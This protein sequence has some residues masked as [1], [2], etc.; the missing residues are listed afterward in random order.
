M[1]PPLRQWDTVTK[2]LVQFTRLAKD[3]DMCY[4]S[5]PIT[6]TLRNITKHLTVEMPKR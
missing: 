4:L 1:M 3:L 2:L 6:G 5:Q